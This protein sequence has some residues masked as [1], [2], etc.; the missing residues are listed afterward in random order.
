MSLPVLAATPWRPR[1]LVHPGPVHPVRIEHRQAA[2][3]RHVRL[4]LEPGRTLHEALVEPLARL[5]IGCASMTLL[6]GPLASLS[7]CVATTD[8]TGVR[9]AA[10]GRPIE[11]GAAVL[12]FGNA[13]LSRGPEDRPLIHCHAAFALA[14]GTLRGGHVVTDRT[15]V[16]DVPIPVLVTAIDGFGL[17]QGYDDETHMPLVRPVDVPSSSESLQETL[18]VR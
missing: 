11:A 13:T 8:P 9:V 6:G 14:D 15:R 2:S 12:V 4:A 16:G 7:Y 5:G 18:H 1:T 3:A 10:Y 17:R